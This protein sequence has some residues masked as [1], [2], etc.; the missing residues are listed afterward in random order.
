MS[1]SIIF[2]MDGTLADVEHRRA[3]IRAK[4]KNWAAWNAGIGDDQPRPEIV[5]LAQMYHR[6][7]FEIIVCTGREENARVVTESWMLHHGVPCHALYM[8][9]NK[10]YRADD[11]VKAELLARIRADGFAPKIAVDDRN[12][13]VAMWRAAGL[14][15]LQCAEGDF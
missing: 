11:E 4:P 13:V 8:R 3:H 1:K 5:H 14:I 7:G 10:D 6:E 15:C 12:R 9:A 2:D